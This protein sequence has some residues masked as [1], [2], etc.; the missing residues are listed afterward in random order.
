M[1]Q[2]ISQVDQYEAKKKAA[3]QAR[4]DE[5]QLRNFNGAQ[6]FDQLYE[7]L[8]SEEIKFLYTYN[9][10]FHKTTDLLNDPQTQTLAASPEEA[11][12]IRDQARAAEQNRLFAEAR[13]AEEANAREEKL[14]E[15]VE[16]LA[17]GRYRL[18]IDPLDGSSPE[19]FYGDTQAAVWAAL[20]KS[21]ANATKEL[22]RRA[23]QVKIT[24]ELREMTVDVVEYA[25]LEV[26]V[27]LAPAELFEATEMLKDPSTS[28]EG[29][30]RLQAAAR[31]DQ[32]IARANEALIRGRSIE[33]QTIAEKWLH[34]NP[35]FYACDHNIG[36]LREIMGTLNWAVTP[37]N[38]SLA[39]QALIEQNVL[40]DK[41]PEAEVETPAFA[42]P[43]PRQAF[44]PKAVAPPAPAAPQAPRSTVPLRRPTMHDPSQTSFARKT[45]TPIRVA[46]MTER[47]AS[48]IPA[49]EMKE[50]YNS[51]ANFR[52]RMDAY[53]AAGGR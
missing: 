3:Q 45:A 46:P 29:T 41:L 15:G 53:W 21:K 8:S 1:A 37:K 52:A 51:D 40:V 42:Q 47:E 4:Q 6:D 17:D 10:S 50:R 7:G 2:K 32:D 27:T 25:P 49:S 22:R 24:Q 30:R 26:K 12:E 44:V 9:E 13:A 35:T 20:R 19:V 39:H 14:Y 36:A 31:T 28:I 33:A 23:G 38:L 11:A 48:S 34:E 43:R 16:K 5:L 18:T